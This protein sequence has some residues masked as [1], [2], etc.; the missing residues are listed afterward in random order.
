MSYRV[1]FSPEADAEL[2]GIYQHV[3]REASAIVAERFPGAIVDHCEGFETFPERGTLRNDIRLGLRIVGFRR[4]VTIAFTIDAN[5]VTII[6]VLYGPGHRS[7]S[8][9]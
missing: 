7:D 6:G 2:R 3:A 8:E 9:G 4:R 1:V 5:V